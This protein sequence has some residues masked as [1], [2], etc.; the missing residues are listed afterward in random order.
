MERVQVVEKNMCK[1]KSWNGKKTKE[2]VLH[3]HHRVYRGNVKSLY[4]EK[5]QRLFKEEWK[6][7]NQ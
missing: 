7:Y 1:Q 4:S 2:G 3:I 5:D 6:E